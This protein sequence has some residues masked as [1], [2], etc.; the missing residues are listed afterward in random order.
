[1][2][3]LLLEQWHRPEDPLHFPDTAFSDKL[4]FRFSEEEDN[5]GFPAELET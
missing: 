3:Y 4:H 1:M 5:G 2:V